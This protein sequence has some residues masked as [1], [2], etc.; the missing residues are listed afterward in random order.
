M[1]RKIEGQRDDRQTYRQTDR[2][3]LEYERRI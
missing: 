3:R 2:L 1:D